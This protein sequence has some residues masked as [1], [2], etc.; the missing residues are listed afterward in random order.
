M[1]VVAVGGRS[2]APPFVA[3]LV[4][5]RCHRTRGLIA[6]FVSLNG[7]TKPSI[8]EAAWGLMT[9]VV[10]HASLHSWRNWIIGLPACLSGVTAARM[11]WKCSRRAW[12][13]A[14]LGMTYPPPACCWENKSHTPAVAALGTQHAGGAGV[15][16]LGQPDR[17]LG[18]VGDEA[19]RCHH[20]PSGY[21]QLL[22]VPYAMRNQPHE[23][24]VAMQKQVSAPLSACPSR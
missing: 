23:P 3:D 11:L 2:T 8:Y 19:S 18:T 21:E 15:A 14:L 7:A 1:V 22:L 9:A 20:G 5:C 4:V 24:G 16:A 12:A 10:L 6:A 17:L 13:A